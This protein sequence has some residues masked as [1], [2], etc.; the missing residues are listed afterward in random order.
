MQGEEIECTPKPSIG[1]ILHSALYIGA[2]GYGGPAML[3]LMKRR[4]VHQRKWVSE[5]DFLNA[6]GIAQA[7]PG[8]TAVSLM[9]FVGYRLRGL[10]GWALSSF[11]FILP[12]FLLTTTLAQFYFRYHNLYM[13][14][15][16]FAGL[17]AL[18]VGLLVNAAV[19]LGRPVFR[20]SYRK[21]SGHFIIT[22]A[23]FLLSVLTDLNTMGLVL[24]SAA[25]GCALGWLIGECKAITPAETFGQNLPK[26]GSA[27]RDTLLVLMATGIL[28]VVLRRMHTNLWLLSTTFLQIGTVAFG[29][30]FTAIPLIKSVV[31]D[32][33]HWLSLNE[34]RDGIAVAQITPGPVFISAAFIG[35]KVAG[36]TGAAVATAAV[37]LPSLVILIPVSEL[38]QRVVGLRLFQNSVGGILAGFIGILATLALQFAEKSLLGWHAWVTFGV[39][40]A[41]VSVMKKD[42]LWA[43]LCAVVL[44]LLPV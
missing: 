31:V 20:G 18:V 39:T 36:W 32:N 2:T 10:L 7:L 11:P 27:V 1:R 40:L 37:F 21:Q 3:A 15:R 24:L 41:I 6:L 42:V 8:S 26:S 9:G 16:L 19:E 30:G 25:L 17:G 22:S 29:N 28:L 38:H 33:H 5:E 13:V 35:Y 43:I 23:V 12:A 34:F 44:S 14:Q 4:L